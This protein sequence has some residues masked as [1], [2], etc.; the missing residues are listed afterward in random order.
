MMRKN[1][2]PRH[3]RPFVVQRSCMKFYAKNKE[4]TA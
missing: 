4:E 1:F 2:M 3:L